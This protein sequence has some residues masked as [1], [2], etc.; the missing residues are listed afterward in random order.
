MP[1][2]QPEPTL[3]EIVEH[4]ERLERLLEHCI[5]RA[6]ERQWKV[7]ASMTHEALERA[8]ASQAAEAREREGPE[9]G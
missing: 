5:G 8:V 3:R 7:L 2:P 1:A 9:R 4:L 6:L